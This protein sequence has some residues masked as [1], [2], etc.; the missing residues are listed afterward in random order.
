MWWQRMRF[1]LGYMTREVMIKGMVSGAFWIM[2][3]LYAEGAADYLDTGG[4]VAIG[5][6]GL[7]GGLFGAVLGAITGVAIGIVYVIAN[8]VFLRDDMSLPFYRYALM[9]L[10]GLLGLLS[11][12]PAYL[13]TSD[14]G[15]PLSGGLLVAA[16]VVASTYT[17][18]PEYIERIRFGQLYDPYDMGNGNRA[19]EYDPDPFS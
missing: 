7:F 16:G 6:A 4:Y 15:M 2:F 9:A 3:W 5:F 12:A 1:T 13:D 17:Y 10:G 14:M 18:L 8:G 11:W 19:T